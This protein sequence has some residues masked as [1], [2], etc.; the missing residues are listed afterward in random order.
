MCSLFLL[1]YVCNYFYYSYTHTNLSLIQI[2]KTE[3]NNL[4]TETFTLIALVTT[5]IAWYFPDT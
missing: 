3:K 5:F 1:T 2:Q 4:A